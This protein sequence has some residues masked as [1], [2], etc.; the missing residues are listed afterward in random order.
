MD[1]GSGILD[2]RWYF[3][4]QGKI[5]KEKSLILVSNVFKIPPILIL[6]SDNYVML[7]GGNKIQRFYRHFLTNK[8]FCYWESK[9][10]HLVN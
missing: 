9:R 2:W 5:F 1:F 3:K 4:L 7:K 8:K 6:K 10:H